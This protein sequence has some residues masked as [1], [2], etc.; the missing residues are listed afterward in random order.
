MDGQL[1]Y[2]ARGK[3]SFVSKDSIYTMWLSNGKQRSMLL[4]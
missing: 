1:A 4:Q 3:P 2:N